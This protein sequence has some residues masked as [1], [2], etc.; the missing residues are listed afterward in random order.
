MCAR[1]AALFRAALPA[2]HALVYSVE[3]VTV[4]LVIAAVIVLVVAAFKCRRRA[5]YTQQI[6]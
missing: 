3:P 6:E 4:V 1:A 5:L 2:A